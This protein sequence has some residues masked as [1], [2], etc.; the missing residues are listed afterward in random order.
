[1][2]YV[3]LDGIQNMAVYDAVN[4][5][6]LGVAVL[7]SLYGIAGVQ[8][9]NKPMVAVLALFQLAS[10]VWKTA[11][12]CFYMTQS[13]QD[14]IQ[15][16]CHPE[17]G[18]LPGELCLYENTLDYVSRHVL[19]LIMFIS[20]GVVTILFIWTLDRPTRV[21]PKEDFVP[22]G[23]VMI[24]MDEPAPAYTEKPFK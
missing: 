18:I 10:F 4:N 20:S 8:S 5:T 6:Y 2:L 17:N 19:S 16:I 14:K 9:N 23:S 3:I 12:F 7:F 1:M 15:A 24:E 11:L 13:M 21:E 22:F